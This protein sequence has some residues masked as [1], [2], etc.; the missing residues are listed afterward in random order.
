MQMIPE[1]IS[2]LTGITD[3]MVAGS[4]SFKE[5]LAD[6]IEFAGD[7]VLVGHN[8]GSFDLKFI[9]RDAQKF[10]ESQLGNDYIDTLPLS[11]MYL[12]DIPSHALTELAFHYGISP[13]GAHRALN[14]CRMNRSVYECLK[15]E[16]ENPSEAAK[17]IEKCPKCGSMLKRRNG[18][19]GEFLGCTGFPDC[20]YTRNI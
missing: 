19:F 7:D 6:F 18:R 15:Q 8:I 3:D 20:K 2:K 9:Q 11:R 17:A 14:D 16:I 12:P 10:F 5:A 4:P 13:E 1:R